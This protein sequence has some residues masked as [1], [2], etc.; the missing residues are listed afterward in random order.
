MKITIPRE[1][2]LVEIERR[3]FDR[4]C[5]TR[6]RI[7]LTKEEARA[8]CGFECERCGRKWKDVLT[9]RDVP[10]WWEG[11]SI[12]DLHAIRE[13]ADAV[14]DEPGEVVKRMSEDFRRLQREGETGE[15]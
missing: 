10:E 4:E 11:L 14:Q 1:L 7:G 3:C 6:T 9:E 2:L 5:N 12:T 13:D 8:Y 15:E